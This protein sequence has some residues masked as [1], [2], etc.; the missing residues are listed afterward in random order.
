MTGSSDAD[1]VGLTGRK[2]GVMGRYI[3]IG[4]VKT[5]YDEQGEGDPLV[6]LHGG[7][8]PNES[9]G[10]QMREF[11]AR[12]R[13]LA[14]ERRGHG[15]TPDVEGPL[16]YDAMAADMIGFIEKVVGGPVHLVG[17]SDGGIVG[18]LVA[19][20]R[21]DLVRKLVVFGANYDIAGVPAELQEGLGAVTADSE[22]M[23]MPRGMHQAVAPGGPESW[24][25]LFGKFQAMAHT[26][27]HITVEELGRISAP[28]LVLSGDDDLPTLEHTVSL[29]RSI[30]NSELAVVPGTSHAVA[31][32]K[33]DV[34]NRIVID[35]LEKEP[36]STMM[37]VRRAP[38][39]QH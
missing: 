32:E 23:A 11:S 22:D 3:D 2:G 36:V 1:T 37:P 29:Y 26:Q 19:I 5:W 24:N 9:W 25:V 38:A 18:L 20:E 4:A 39:G 28:T 15:R 35:F 7:L 14:P 31:M 12:F 33:P 21:P 8:V 13:V 6:L 10:M 27:P 30:P 16:S 17:W 34:L